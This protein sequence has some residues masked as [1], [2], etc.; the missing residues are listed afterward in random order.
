MPNTITGLYPVLFEAVDIVSRELVGFIPAV[1][2][3]G[4]EERAAVGQTVTSFQTRAGVATDITPGVTPPDDGD[5]ALDPVS[6]TITKARRVPVRWNGEQ[7]KQINSGPGVSNVVADQ[8]AQAMRTLVNEI[9]SDIAALYWRASRAYGAAGTTP[10]ATDLSDPANVLK[11]LLDNGAPQGDLQLVINTTAGAKV[12]SLATLNKVNEAGSAGL[13][14]QGVLLDI[15]GFKLR[16]SAKVK[17]VTKGTG[18]GYVV[19]NAPGYASGSTALALSTGAGTIL[20]GDILTFAG[21]A[22][23]YVAGSALAGGNISL[24]N[25]GLQ[26]LLANGVAATVGNNFTA[27]MAFSRN[28]IQLATR[29][30]ALPTQGDS[31]IDRTLITDPVSG[32]TFEIAQYPQY[33]QMQYEVSIAW[34]VSVNKPEHLA[35]LLG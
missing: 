33:R 24:N 18:A 12:R 13:L 26:Q 22:N 19:N 4:S 2:M 27:N 31:A 14:N 20:A 29:A 21:D 28:A 17:T 15:H 11:I 16:E 3:D 23:K 25:P 5:Q 9:E 32:L 7:S 30:P 34:G 6:M 10:F 8:F 1:S 35:L